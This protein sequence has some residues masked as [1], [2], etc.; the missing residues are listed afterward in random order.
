[1]ITAVAVTPLVEIS[2][3]S[4]DFRKVVVSQGGN[5]IAGKSEIIL[6]NNTEKDIN[7]RIDYNGVNSKVFEMKQTGTIFSFNKYTLKL[8]FRPTDPVDY[9]GS[10]NI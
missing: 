2:T 10:V 7:F 5:N 8:N 1:M 9:M 3:N 4:V 6:N